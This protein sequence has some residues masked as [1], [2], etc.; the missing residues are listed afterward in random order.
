ME[1]KN[2]IWKAYHLY[3]LARDSSNG[4]TRH[5]LDAENRNENHYK[6]KRYE[7]YSKLK[8]IFHADFPPL[9]A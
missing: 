7:E 2:S 8:L 1:K 3:I 9:S 6:N 5:F 4:T